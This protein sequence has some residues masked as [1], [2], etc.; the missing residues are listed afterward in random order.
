MS[1]FELQILLPIHN[2]AESIDATIREIYVV[3]PDGR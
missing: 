1:A 2:E 3:H